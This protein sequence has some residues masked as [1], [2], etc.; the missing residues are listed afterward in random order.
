[1]VWGA[2]WLDSWGSPHRSELVIMP[3]DF[4]SEKHGYSGNSYIK[5]LEEGLLPYYQPGVRFQQDNVRIHEARHVKRWFEDHGIWV[6]K[7]PRYSPDLNPIEHMWHALKRLLHKLYPDIDKLGHSQEDLDY[8]CKCMKEAWKK[9]PNSLIFKLIDGMPVV[10]MPCAR[11]KAG[12]RSTYPGP[13]YLS[14]H[15][16]LAI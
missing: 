15:R 9:I 8:L 2:I 14:L 13:Y 6:V 7:W 1:M 3:R 11:Q 10:W 4:E 12:R 16:K 5:T